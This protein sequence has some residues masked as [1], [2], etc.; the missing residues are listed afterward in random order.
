MDNFLKNKGHQI[1]KYN[2][3]KIEH[4][5]ICTLKNNQD[6]IIVPADKGGAIT[7]LDTK[8]Y[9]KEAESQLQNN[10]FYVPLPLDP[11]STF[12]TE[13]SSLTQNLNRNIRNTINSLIPENPKTVTFYTIPKLHKLPKIISEKH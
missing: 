8:N 9:I 10:R 7:T 1:K 5:A 3:S 12:K 13:L 4:Q 11:T 6:I 2:L